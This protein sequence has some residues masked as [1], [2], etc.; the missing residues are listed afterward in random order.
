METGRPG[1][2]PVPV[3]LAATTT[4][5][6]WAKMTKKGGNCGFKFSKGYKYYDVPPMEILDMAMKDK[7][8]S[9]L[10]NDQW[11]EENTKQIVKALLE[12]LSEQFTGNPHYLSSLE[13]AEGTNEEEKD[14]ASEAESDS[15][16]DIKVASKRKH[17]RIDS[18]SD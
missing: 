8:G 11:T 6:L 7:Y 18:D 12:E 9:A 17:A 4:D 5:T 2:K 1:E 3:G 14:D 13:L 16:Q 15:D 10:G